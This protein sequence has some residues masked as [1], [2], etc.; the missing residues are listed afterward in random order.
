MK[1]K[2]VRGRETQRSLRFCVRFLSP[3]L[4]GNSIAR[5]GSLFRISRVSGKLRRKRHN[6]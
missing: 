6:K 1:E 3:P 5:G 4:Y 2:V